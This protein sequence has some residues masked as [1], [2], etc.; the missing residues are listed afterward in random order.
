MH[1]NQAV[2]VAA[3]LDSV[4]L[5][6]FDCMLLLRVVALTLCRVFV[7]GQNVVVI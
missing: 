2:F 5:F 1:N 3:F 7:V 4:C 6:D